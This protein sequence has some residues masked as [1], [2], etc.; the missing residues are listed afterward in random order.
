MF[1]HGTRHLVLLTVAGFFSVSLAFADTFSITGTVDQSNIPDI[2]V[3]EQFHGILI[4]ANHCEVCT[5]G[6]PD[7]GLTALSLHVFGDWL[8]LTSADQM[9]ETT[10]F[11]RSMTL[12]FVDTTEPALLIDPAGPGRHRF[13]FQ[14]SWDPALPFANGHYDI[15]PVPEPSGW[16]LPLPVALV[17][18]KYTVHRP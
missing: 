2:S 6:T 17:L 11:R 7:S 15:A 14:D 9:D 8:S 12:E 4:T 16:W 18:R 5:F 13:G 1:W 10:F 3:G